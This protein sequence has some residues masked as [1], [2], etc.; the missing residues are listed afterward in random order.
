MRVVDSRGLPLT[1]TAA[2][3]GHYRDGVDAWLRVQEG[4]GP[5]MLAAR[6]EDPGFAL[7]AAGL[8]L[9]AA[10]RGDTGPARTWLRAAQADAPRASERE[11]SHVA[12][13]AAR[14]EQPLHH[15]VDHLA[16]HVRRHPR[17]ALAFSA[18][19]STLLYSGLPGLA[20][21]L[22]GLTNG[23]RPV[24]V[25]GRRLVVARHRGVLAIGTGSVCGVGG[26]G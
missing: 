14:V 4:F 22:V 20:A 7:A 1:T 24:G 5:A 18:T 3:A 19:M 11:R 8:A 13:A 16:G 15:A 6:R 9:D 25:R 17:D 12:A 26:P 21:R 10:V 23:R 2:A